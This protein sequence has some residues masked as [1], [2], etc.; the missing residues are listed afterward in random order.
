MHCAPS[1]TPSPV[2]LEDIL[3]AIYRLGSFI[4]ELDILLI[5][6]ELI[7]TFT[8]YFTYNS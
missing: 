7:T 2:V 8:R 4:E 6:V 1:R 3:L 5:T